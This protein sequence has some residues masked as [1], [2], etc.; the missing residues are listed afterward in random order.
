MIYERTSRTYTLG[1]QALSPTVKETLSHSRSWTRTR[2]SLPAPHVRLR[3]RPS[4]VERH[5]DRHGDPDNRVCLAYADAYAPVGTYIDG[6][7]TFTAWTGSRASRCLHELYGSW[8]GVRPSSTASGIVPSQ[9]AVPAR[10][11]LHEPD[12]KHAAGRRQPALQPQ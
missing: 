11:H 5:R 7:V 4:E 12:A 8:G 9:V 10:I 2:C 6:A 3:D 1:G